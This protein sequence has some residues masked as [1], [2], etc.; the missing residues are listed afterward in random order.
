MGRAIH[1]SHGKEKIHHGTE[2]HDRSELN[3]LYYLIT[4]H[5]RQGTLSVDFFPSS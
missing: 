4:S 3:L 1:Q 2:S 5:C